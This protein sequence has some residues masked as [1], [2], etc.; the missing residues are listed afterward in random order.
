MT[1]RRRLVYL[2]EEKIAKDRPKLMGV[3]ELSIGIVDYL[4]ANN[5]ITVACGEWIPVKDNTFMSPCY[6]CSVCGRR[7][8]TFEAP[9]KVTPYCHCGAKMDEVSK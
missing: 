6:E 2:I 1:Q 7:F 3:N 4:I 8:N 5:A 9:T